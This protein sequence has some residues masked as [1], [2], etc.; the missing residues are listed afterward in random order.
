MEGEIEYF[1]FLPVTFTTDLQECLEETLADIMQH[2]G[3]TSTRM[4]TRLLD[5]F[6]KNVF[7]FNN[8]VLRNI[9]RF[10]PGFRLE[11]R[12]TDCTIQEDPR[13][14]A[15][16]VA[17]TQKHLMRL[18]EERVVLCDWLCALENRNS[19]YR[20]LL[21]DAARYREIATGARE[22]RQYIR[23]TTEVYENFRISAC[24]RESDFESLMEFKNIKNV[25]FKGERD[26]LLGVAGFETLEYL[27]KRIKQ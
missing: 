2:N 6:R 5:A 13:K 20:S 1:G 17:D 9:L 18:R 26:R 8:F 23:E 25:Y 15:C 22:V 4:R 11:R 10:P 3:I 12:V 7:I 19:A 24:R 27:N 21:R 16:A 14:L